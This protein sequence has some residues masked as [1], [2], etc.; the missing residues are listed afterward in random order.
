MV[1]LNLSSYYLKMGQEHSIPQ[2]F[3]EAEIIISMPK[4][5]VSS[6]KSMDTRIM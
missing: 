5:S 1:S 4:D 6:K 2:D 3:C